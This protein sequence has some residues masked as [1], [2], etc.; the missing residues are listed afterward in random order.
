M[1]FLIS[2][3]P[4]IKARAKET[5]AHPTSIDWKKLRGQPVRIVYERERDLRPL[6]RAA[7]ANDCSP[8]DVLDF[9]N[10][11]Y[12][13]VLYDTSPHRRIKKKF[14][15]PIMNP[16]L[17]FFHPAFALFLLKDYERASRTA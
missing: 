4:A 17:E 8:I 14:G 10:I 9:E 13:W 2:L 3:V 1:N 16:T 7:M 12:A 5:T 15:I 11:D 6:L